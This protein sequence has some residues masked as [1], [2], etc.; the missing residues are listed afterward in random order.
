[1]TDII[2]LFCI[3][4]KLS[5]LIPT[6]LLA[7]HKNIYNVHGTPP[8]IYKKKLKKNLSKYFEFN[9][10]DFYKI[11]KFANLIFLIFYKP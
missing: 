7:L 4:Q 2:I 5:P 8:L 3:N 1:M 9:F 11:P 6:K 10:T